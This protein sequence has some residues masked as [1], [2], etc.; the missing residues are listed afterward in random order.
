M[1]SPRVSFIV[2]THARAQWL[3]GA[4]ASI[5]RQTV[6][7]REIVVVVNGPDPET[8]QLLR[9]LG[10]EARV[11]VLEHN[12][13]VGA[14]RNA[15]VAL[16][17]G[18]IL[19]FL[20][21]DAELRDLDTAMRLLKHFERDPELGVVGFLVMD[22]ATGAIESRCIP[23]RNKRVPQGPTAACYFAGGACAIRRAVF[24][25]VGFYDESLFY[26]GEE[27][28]LSY[29]LLEA[30]FRILF[31]PSVA[32]LHYAVGDRSESFALY[33]SARNRP[34]VALRHLPLLCCVTH[35]VAW[36]AWSLAG[37]LQAGAVASALRGMRDCVA[38]TP[39]I[40]RK[41]RP[42]SRRTTQFLARNS[43]RLWY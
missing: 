20:D 1:T 21:D 37:G 29:R 24:D 28:D 9:A 11:A 38:G 2:V 43:G 6:N 7:C 14:G 40:W 15:G 34:W 17:R 36:W 33:F 3:S 13:G 26:G 16:A 22:A 4:L 35:I 5:Q 42:I 25:R 39:E 27:V 10:S 12:Y 8:Q 41:R 19:V 32:M 30:G 23:F 31:D 18:E